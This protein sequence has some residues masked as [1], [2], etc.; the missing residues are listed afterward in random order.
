MG[1]TGMTFLRKLSNFMLF[2][3]KSLKLTKMFM[4]GCI[5][6]SFYIH[7]KFVKDIF[8]MYLMFSFIIYIY[9]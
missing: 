5:V 1:I 3:M 7:S 6:T 9:I 8:V 2:S 4:G